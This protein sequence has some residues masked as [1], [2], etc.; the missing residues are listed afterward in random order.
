MNRNC[1]VIGTVLLFLSG[2]SSSFKHNELKT[3]ELKL[4]K[5]VGVLISTPEN[6]W[7]EQR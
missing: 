6:G 1:I 3:P 4:D 7:Y 5:S 2:C